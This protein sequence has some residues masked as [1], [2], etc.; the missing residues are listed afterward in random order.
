M[1]LNPY[2]ILGVSEYDSIEIIEK[3]YRKLLVTITNTD[4]NNIIKSAFKM[5]LDMRKKSSNLNSKSNQMNNVQSQ[6]NPVQSQMNPVQNQLNPVQYNQPYSFQYGT[7]ILTPPPTSTATGSATP[8]GTKFD[9]E[10]FN[11]K[12]VAQNYNKINKLEEDIRQNRSKNQFLSEQSQIENELKSIKQLDFNGQGFNNSTFNKLFEY[13]NGKPEKVFNSNNNTELIPAADVSNSG[14]LFTNINTGEQIKHDQFSTYN[15]AFTGNNNT[16]DIDSDLI[17]SLSMQPDITITN[18]I[19]DNSRNRMKQKMEDIKTAKFELPTQAEGMK[20]IKRNEND[21]V[22][23]LSQKDLD[24]E[25]QMKMMERNS[26]M[27]PIANQA[28]PIPIQFNQMQPQM[29]PQYQQGQFQQMQPIQ[30]M[31]PMQP[32]QQMQPQFQQSQG[33]FQPQFQQGQQ[34]QPQFQQFQPQFQPPSMYDDQLNQLR[35]EI[36]KQNELIKKLSGSD[37]R[38]LNYH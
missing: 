32:M 13:I 5:I 25:M 27:N 9:Q 19:D 10:D 26:F 21:V 18:N 33:Q 29:Q 12:F 24:R 28:N 22:Q 23:A 4:Q 11:K 2:Q 16:N 14:L 15:T 8:T 6:M 30:P 35:Q 34:S 20:F 31:Q 1:S 17:K 36:N 38:S 3:T 37:N 7:P